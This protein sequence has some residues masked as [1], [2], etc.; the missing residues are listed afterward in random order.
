MAKGQFPMPGGIVELQGQNQRGWAVGITPLT[1]T[2]TQLEEARIT[3]SRTRGSY[4]LAGSSL[5]LLLVLLS[6]PRR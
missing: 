4:P 6:P 5:G 2:P 3:I 1:T